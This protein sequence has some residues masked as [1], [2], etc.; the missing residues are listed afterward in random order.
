TVPGWDEE[1]TEVSN[2]HELPLNAQNY[3]MLIEEKT[4]KPITIIGVGPKRR[5][6]IFR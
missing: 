2:F 6:T 3:I 4:G 1:I 5:Q